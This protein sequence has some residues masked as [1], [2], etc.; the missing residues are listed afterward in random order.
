MRKWL[1]VLVSSLLLSTSLS[2]YELYARVDEVQYFTGYFGWT[3]PDNGAWFWLDDGSAWMRTRES[4]P[5]Y[6]LQEG[7]PI[8]I[9]SMTPE[10]QRHY[11]IRGDRNY[12]PYWIVLENNALGVAYNYVGY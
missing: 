7:Q 8:C 2:A 6:Y 11:R 4:G 3:D 12:V 9:I 5:I 10:E 1:C